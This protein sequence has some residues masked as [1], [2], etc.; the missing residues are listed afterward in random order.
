MTSLLDMPNDD[1]FV[2]T[3]RVRHPFVE[4]GLGQAPFRCLGANHNENGSACR[5]C[6]TFIKW[7]FEIISAD[8]RTFIVGSE[9]VKRT[10]GGIAGFDRQLRAVKKRQRDEASARKREREAD[11][12][13]VRFL[14]W[15]AANGELW[16][17]LNAKRATFEFARSLLEW[18][19]KH[20]EL[21]S[22][23]QSAAERIMAEDTVRQATR[24]QER[25]AR[26]Q[27]APVVDV[28]AIER[29]FDVARSRGVGRPKLR[30]DA[31]VFKLAGAYS[32][33]PGAVYVTAKD[34]DTYLGKVMRGKFYRA[35]E[36]A[37]GQEQAIVNACAD[38]GAAAVAFGKRYGACSVCGRTLENEES[39]NRGIGPICAEKFGF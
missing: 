22:G 36:C 4:A 3:P 12:A 11:A 1:P 28:A 29:A 32:A 31:F 5:Y 2:D 26:E 16:D 9:C 39:I 8:Q 33:N 37:E 38:P 18:L 10:G 19:T 24:A 13:R 23:Q 25:E 34:N 27:A 17:W 6:G 14:A 35:R 7:E 15:H 21:T 20:G 30:L